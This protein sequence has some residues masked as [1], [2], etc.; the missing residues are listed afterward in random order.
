MRDLHMRRL[1]II[2]AT[3]NFT[4]LETYSKL[5][6]CGDQNTVVSS[7]ELVWVSRNIPGVGKQ[8]NLD[9]QKGMLR[10]V[11]Y[12]RTLAGTAQLFPPYSDIDPDTTFDIVIPLS[13]LL[14]VLSEPHSFD[15]FSTDSRATVF[16]QP[17]LRL[18]PPVLISRLSQQHKWARLRA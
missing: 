2:T 17:L 8:T 7:W 18:W 11:R 15:L 9:S 14:L 1:I 16:H 4:V 13:F 12:E 3:F 6:I 5:I 10:R